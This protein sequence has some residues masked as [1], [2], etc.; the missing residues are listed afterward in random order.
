MWS[1]NCTVDLDKSDEDNALGK[2]TCPGYSVLVVKKI[3][4]Q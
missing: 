2:N 1:V 4:R 3:E